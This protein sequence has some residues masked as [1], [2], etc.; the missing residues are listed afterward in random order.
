MCTEHTGRVAQ[1]H[2]DGT[3][4]GFSRRTALVGGA[5]AAVTAAL[6][7]TARAEDRTTRGPNWGRRG[8]C[9]LTHPLTTSLPMFLPTE[10]PSRR[11]AVTIEQN[12]YYQQEWRV[13]E[14]TGTHV[15]APGHFTPGGRLAPELRIDELVTPAVVID[16]STRAADDP[17]TVVTIDDVRAHEERHGRIPDDAAVLMDSGWGSRI[18]DPEAYRGA[19]A[20]GT[21][22]FPGFGP[23]T[24]EWLL[25]HRRIRSLGVDTLS[26]DPGVSTTFDTHLL[27]SGADR[28]G[29][30]N[31]AHLD[32][33]P[34]TGATIAVGLIPFEEGSGGPARV[35]AS[36]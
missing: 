25:A 19:D 6:T 33:L 17:D 9:D 24:C 23:D 3:G 32:R 26:L 28:Y 16:I 20:A 31:L 11:T 35:F 14:H 27:L 1:Q 15:D 8:L 2:R 4:A 5:A 10:T 21:L 18:G 22:H 13:F 7:G 30:E 12:G 29:M 34:P 36:W